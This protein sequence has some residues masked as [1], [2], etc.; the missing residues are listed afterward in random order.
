[1]GQIIFC[2][3]N[4][5]NRF[6]L[7]G[8]CFSIFFI[9]KSTEAQEHFGPAYSN[10][11]PTSSLFLNPASIVDSKA[12]LDIHLA[13]VGAFFDNDL[14]YLSRNDFKLT[15]GMGQFE[16][17]ILP[18]Q[19]LNSSPKQAY[20]S[21]M[22]QG[23]SISTTIGRF[24][25]GF[26]TAA[27]HVTDARNISP[28]LSNYIF[29]GLSFAPQSNM[30]FNESN[31]RANTLAWAEVGVSFGGILMQK[32]NNQLQSGVTARRLYGIGA[33]SV[34]LDNLE[35]MVEDSSQMNLYD[36]T[37]SMATTMP[38]WNSGRGWGFNVGFV[39]KKMKEDVSGY[40]PHS[41]QSGCESKD[42]R[43]KIGASLLDVGSIRF[44]KMTNVTTIN[45]ASAEINYNE[46]NP[47]GV[48][49]L[50]S[51]IA[52]S[53][54]GEITE[55]HEF[56]IALP[57]AVSVQ[58][59]YNLGKNFYVASSWVHGFV[60]KNAGVTRASLVNISPRFEHKNVE[61]SLPFTLYDYKNPRLGLALR[62]NNIVIGTDRLGPLIFNPDV[63][64][65]DLYVQ[66]KYTLYKSKACKQRKQKQ[67][68]VDE[69]GIMPSCPSW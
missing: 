17:E 61:V 60:P 64:G 24:S 69:S 47:S 41:K 51:L 15:R 63:Y 8:I 14:V 5:L 21:A 10:Y 65:M 44:D 29:E 7:A 9:S 66:I 46:I 32:G 30:V 50:D 67:A 34:Q 55:A 6:Y 57:M 13:G 1:V 53:V 26:H 39:Y 59:D 54:S 18:Q 49:E 48:E 2:L 68:K 12:Y 52:A 33:A 56:K 23:P 28:E 45:H 4:F 38:A 27:R 58:L 31:V 19:N 3:M 43:Y 42:Y 35:F 20:T 62:F 40:K 16:G 22:I 25:V 11:S 37:G 36:L